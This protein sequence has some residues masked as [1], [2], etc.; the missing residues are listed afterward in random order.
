MQIVYLNK[1][2]YFES[3]GVHRCA[4]KYSRPYAKKYLEHHKNISDGLTAGHVE[5]LACARLQ[6]ILEVTRERISDI[7]SLEEIMTLLEYNKEGLFMPQHFSSIPEFLCDTHGIDFDKYQLSYLNDL[8]GK[9]SGLDDL[10][11]FALG[12]ALEQTWRRGMTNETSP[13]DFLHTL[14]IELV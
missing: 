4:L 5:G 14:G 1:D 13:R 10:Q 2:D 3:T 12:D 11:F 7:F 8:V 6:W 9:L